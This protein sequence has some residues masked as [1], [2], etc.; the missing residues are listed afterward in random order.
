[1]LGI[2]PGAGHKGFVRVALEQRA[3]LVPVL[4]IGEVLQIANGWNWP[5]LQQLTYKKLGFPIPYI[6]VGR[7]GFSPLPCKVSLDPDT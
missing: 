5:T 4:A 7:W 1:M 6:M 3:A 2:S